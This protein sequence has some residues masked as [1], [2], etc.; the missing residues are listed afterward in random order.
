MKKLQLI[1]SLILLSFTISGCFKKEA[2]KI[3][4]EDVEKGIV[5]SSEKDAV[6]EL[7]KNG[8][9]KIG[10]S[11]V[12]RAFGEQII[13]KTA[14]DKTYKLMEKEGVKSFLGYGE[15]KANN[16]I[17]RAS[18]SM[19]KRNLITSASNKSYKDKLKELQNYISKTVTRLSVNPQN[20][21]ITAEKYMKWLSQPGHTIIKGAPKD[22][23]ILRNNMF[24]VMT[25]KERRFAENT[26]KNGNQAHHIVGNATP[27]ANAKLKKFGID[28]NDPENGI[29]LPSNTRSGLRGTNH[30]GGHTDDYYN[31]IEQL[32]SNCRN[33]DECYEILDKIKNDLYK[34]KIKL[35]NETK[36]QVNKT[37]RT[38]Y[39]A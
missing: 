8:S 32:F 5:H 22:A 11:Y 14:R 28:I 23:S 4:G 24:R 16:E 13:K 34:G 39:A 21:Y 20:Q 19:S 10:K 15:K 9:K 37:F 3:L 38:K 30:R 18:F 1:L 25:P 17:S 6:K 2:A 33:K 12:G 36:H 31:Y 29:F 27:L 26:L 7:A 35:Y